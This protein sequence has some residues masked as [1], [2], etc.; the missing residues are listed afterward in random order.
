MGFVAATMLAIDVGMLM[1]ARSQAQN[2]ADAGAHAGAV[3]LAFDNYDDRSAGG[4]AV[5]NALARAQAN[6]VMAQ[7]VSVEPGDVEFLA[8]VYGFQNRVKVTVYRTAGRGNALSL[9]IAPLFGIAPADVAATATAEASPA[10]SVDCVLPFMIPDQWDEN[11]TEP[12]NSETSTFQLYDKTPNGVPLANPDVYVP[13]TDRVNYTGY[14]PIRDRGTKVV[15]KASVDTTVSPS[16]FHPIVLPGNEGRGAD[17]YQ[18]AIA[19]CVHAEF[20]LEAPMTVEPGNMVGPTKAG[21]EQLVDSD[22]N[23]YWDEDCLCVKGSA[24]PVSPRIRPIPLYD[25]DYY[26]RGKQNGRY[27]DFK[28]A[29]FLGV[30]V[31]GMQGNEVVAFITPIAGSNGS[32]GSVGPPNAFPY[33]VRIVE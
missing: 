6:Q 4:P 18:K 27:A 14:K 3:A 30:F 19:G 25:P 2:S 8:G 22:P 16:I 13:A 29:N 20:E 12:F 11:T 15:L 7:N 32:N 17:D 28:V 21:V 24:F 10:A 26:E 31:K 5:T 23:A 33:V 1:T 9:F